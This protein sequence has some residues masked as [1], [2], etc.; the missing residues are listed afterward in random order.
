[1]TDLDWAPVIFEQFSPRTAG[2][3]VQER[4]IRLGVRG[5]VVTVP[6]STIQSGTCW[7][8][9]SGLTG[10]G[11]PKMRQVLCDL[12]ADLAH[13]PDDAP[14][15]PKTWRIEVPHWE[16][17]TLVIPDPD[18]AARAG[19]EALS[20]Y[21][22][23]ATGA[24][25]EHWREALDI[26]IRSPEGRGPLYLGLALGG[27]FLDALE[28]DHILDP[29]G[30]A[31]HAWGEGRQG[32]GTFQRGVAAVVG[33]P[34]DGRRGGLFWS[35]GGSGLGITELTAALPVLPVIMSDTKTWKR[36]LSEL[37][38]TVMGVFEGSRP[39]SG[40]KGGVIGRGGA[41]R[42]IIGS[43]GN[44]TITNTQPGDQIMARVL[45][46]PA[47]LTNTAKEAHEFKRLTTKGHGLPLELIRNGA[48]PIGQAQD[49][50]LEAMDT[51]SDSTGTRRPVADDVANRAAVLA[52]GARAL[53]HVAGPYWEDAMK[54]R[55]AV[56]AFEMINGVS[57]ALLD[58]HR[59]VAHLLHS[60][61]WEAY[62][63][64]PWAFPKP[65][66]ADPERGEREGFYLSP[67]D[68]IASERLA[69]YRGPLQRIAADIGLHDVT[70]PLSDL[71]R[72]GLIH[73]DKGRLTGSFW[74]DARRVWDVYIFEAPPTPSPQG[75]MI[76]VGTADTADTLISQ[77][78]G[79]NTQGTKEE[80]PETEKQPSSCGISG[81]DPHISGISASY[82]HHVRENGNNCET[83]FASDAERANLT[84][85]LMLAGLNK[86]ADDLGYQ[87]LEQ[88]PQDLADGIRHKLE[89]LVAPETK[90]TSEWPSVILPPSPTPQELRTIARNT[91]GKEL[92]EA[93]YARA[94]VAESLADP[95]RVRFPEP[96][97]VNED[98]A[99]TAALDARWEGREA[100]RATEVIAEAFPGDSAIATEDWSG[101]PLSDFDSP[102]S[103][104]V[105]A[106]AATAPAPAATSPTG[107]GGSTEAP[108]RPAGD[109]V[110]R[111]RAPAPVNE[112]PL[113][114]DATRMVDE[115]HRSVDLPVAA[116]AGHLAA[117]ALKLTGGRRASVLVHPLSHEALGLPA[118]CPCDNDGT[119]PLAAHSLAARAIARGVEAVSVE[120]TD[121]GALSVGTGDTR[122][123][124]A[125][126]AW[127]DDFS[128]DKQSGPETLSLEELCETGVIV[129]DT[130][131]VSYLTSAPSS[132]RHLIRRTTRYSPIPESQ[133]EPDLSDPGWADNLHAM[134]RG[135]WIRPLAAGEFSKNLI[136]ARDRNASY[137]A[138]WES[139]PLGTGEWTSGEACPL[140]T[141][142]GV[143]G[144]W[145]FDPEPLR[146]AFG[147]GGEHPD[148]FAKVRNLEGAQWHTT[149]LAQLAAELA[150]LAGLQLCAQAF[151]VQLNTSTPLRGAGE[152]LRKARGALNGD[153]RPAARAALAVLKEGYVRAVAGFEHG[154]PQPPKPL[155]RPHWRRSIID[156]AMANTFR[157]LEKAE[158]RPFAWGEIDTALFAVD[159]ESEP[160]GLKIGKGLGQFKPKGTAVP[161]AEASKALKAGDI[162]GLPKLIGR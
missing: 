161:M 110:R 147:L 49:W 92:R 87:D 26:A 15:R 22:K 153:T 132:V 97:P 123:D 50:T 28:L 134:P 13:N 157:A 124:I 111:R 90:A 155:A 102:A 95:D 48:I 4:S 141:K 66:D 63:R 140:L 47:P 56:A 74:R 70:V 27:A 61:V 118:E 14:D 160:G 36:P 162:A 12:V 139:Q 31:V 7:E 19:L 52:M 71:R 83:L 159:L 130:L 91:P 54:E 121:S 53:G 46:I 101:S 88:W 33:C 2:G 81:S 23:V 35:W 1:M 75:N 105:V 114:C 150:E 32:K 152:A 84:V 72:I 96:P 115:H 9:F 156:R 126:P 39:V 40:R 25:I 30:F 62:Q 58:S 129:R 34:S 119:D 145:L 94:D 136:V 120:S 133:P 59:P 51:F 142:N 77:V 143:P 68:K 135:L 57:A 128:P 151:H 137:L 21:G 127:V 24:T 11:S 37:G 18:A 93:L 108:S 106:A 113:A 76:R 117:A 65:S 100:E 112:M 45:E 104:P 82:A 20:G 3:D 5:E 55:A 38:T 17:E 29:L 131:G 8:H 6:F 86:W 10:A 146:K 43:S 80:L 60:A 98:P 99:T 78:R 44:D 107:P 79:H 85:R 138:G 16:G 116:D 42:S 154:G 144:Y 89:G 41:Y 148:P 67:T 103:A 122:I 158:P 64:R 69:V 73:H 109:F 149:P 125:F